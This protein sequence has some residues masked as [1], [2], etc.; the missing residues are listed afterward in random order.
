MIS[1]PFPFE[2]FLDTGN[3]GVLRLLAH[4]AGHSDMHGF[5]F[6]TGGEREV[7][8][9]LREA[10]SRHPTRFLHLLSLHWAD[11]STGY[12]DDIMDGV[13]NFLAHRYGNLQPNCTWTP[14]EEPDAH[15]L[16][17]DILD[18]LERHTVHWR[19]NRAASNALQACAHVIQNT[20]EAARLVF[21]ALDFTSLREESSVR[22]DS[23]NL[24]TIGINMMRGHVVDALMILANKLQEKSIDYPELL[25]PTLRR[26]SRDDHPAI[27]VLILRRLPYLQSKNPELGWELYDLATQGDTGGL[28]GSTEQCM[29]YAYHDSFA[30]ISSSLARLHDEGSGKDLE[31]WGRISALAALANRI[32]FTV[33]LETLKTLN[34]IDAWSGAASVWTHPENIKQHRKQCLAGITAGLNTN[35]PLPVVIAQKMSSLLRNTTP[36][37]PIPT[38]LIRR[39]FSVFEN[40]TDDKHHDLFG[41]DRWLNATS[42]RE[43]E[44]ALASAEIYLAYI[45]HTKPYLYDHENN[46]T[47]L[48][49]RLFA[50][51]EE[52]E[53][54]DHGAMLQRVVAM[55]DALLSMGVTSI[56]DWLK[57]A[58]RP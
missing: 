47:Q 2:V 22:G 32:D 10:A 11:I 40:L 56:N 44:H 38:E 19:H 54:F 46:L 36:P 27:R 58:E 25:S 5:D 9:Q 37:I 29:Y 48:L 49:T 33:W 35:D 57:A 51:A 31:T 50:E 17:Q 41:F 18:E 23:V 42:H 39:C 13:S 45:K 4:Y 6:L 20:Q 3:D 52:R 26:F 28:W 1:A 34:S 14:I 43:P 30:K 15:M 7:G 16:A 8:S 24:M 12:R 53:E 55:Q 21:L